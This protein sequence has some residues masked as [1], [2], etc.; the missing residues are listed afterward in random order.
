MND[1]GASFF[2]QKRI[3]KGEAAL[4]FHPQK[5]QV[6]SEFKLAITH[7]LYNIVKKDGL[8]FS[9]SLNTIYKLIQN[10]IFIS[11]TNL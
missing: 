11:T 5:F 2:L 9:F 4:L 8:S 1:F 10:Q 6:N 3:T 7:M